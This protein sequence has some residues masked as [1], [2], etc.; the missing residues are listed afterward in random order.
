MTENRVARLTMASAVLLFAGR[1]VC[2]KWIAE[3]D[4]SAS[5]MVSG[6]PEP[7]LSASY[8]DGRYP[9]ENLADL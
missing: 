7:T 4:R 5:T 2:F 3:V 1:I 8:L 6:R 9:G